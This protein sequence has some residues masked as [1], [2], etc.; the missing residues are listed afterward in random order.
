MTRIEINEYLKKH[1][2][3][4]DEN[5]MKQMDQLHQVAIKT[6]TGKKVVFE[7]REKVVK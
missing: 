6:F 5:Y 7:I 3:A 2:I 4:L 1:K